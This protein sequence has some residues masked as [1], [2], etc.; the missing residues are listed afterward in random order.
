M[1]QS[2][3][4]VLSSGLDLPGSLESAIGQL[5]VATPAIESHRS[6]LIALELGGPARNTSLGI[7]QGGNQLG[8]GRIS[9]FELY[10]GGTRRLI[11][12]IRDP[13]RDA[14]V[15][16]PCDSRGKQQ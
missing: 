7:L 5:F 4:D 10:G 6:N 12:R 16:T 9:L 2:L 1:L 14:L 8:D 15:V 3:V 11:G 13:R